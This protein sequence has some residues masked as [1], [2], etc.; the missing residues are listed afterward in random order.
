MT[1]VRHIVNG[2]EPVTA[3][4]A[5]GRD[6]G[7]GVGDIQWPLDPG[8]AAVMRFD[9]ICQRS[10]AEIGD[11]RAVV[12][13]HD[14]R[15]DSEG[16]Q[17]PAVCPRSSGI[18]GKREHGTIERVRVDAQHHALFR[19]H[20]G[21]LPRKPAHALEKFVPVHMPPFFGVLEKQR[22]PLGVDVFARPDLLDPAVQQVR[23]GAVGF[24]RTGEHHLLPI[25]SGRPIQ[26]V[27]GRVAVLQQEASHF[28]VN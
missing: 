23:E 9:A 15:L 4:Q 18:F 27:V 19:E 26:L 3:G 22:L 28:I 5:Q 12:L 11:Q 21:R 2:Q 8:Q 14:G 24:R 16:H 1:S 20:N 7:S 6:T 17:W 10:V 25:P 13:L